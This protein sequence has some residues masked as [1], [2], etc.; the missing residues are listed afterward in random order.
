MAKM[1]DVLAI[2]FDVTET[3]AQQYQPISQARNVMS[4][5]TYESVA[6]LENI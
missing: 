2:V 4:C 1:G 5:A 3:E 6:I